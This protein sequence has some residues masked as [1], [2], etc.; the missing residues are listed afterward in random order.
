MNEFGGLPGHPEDMPL[1]ELSTAVQETFSGK[2]GKQ[3]T[4]MVAKMVS[5]KFPGSYTVANSRKY[6]QERW[7]FGPGRQ[8]SVLI[9][10]T[11]QQPASRLGSDVDVKAYLDLVAQQYAKSSGL[12]LNSSESGDAGA[13]NT[14][15]VI[16]QAALDHL[17][18]EQRSL[19]KAVL[20]VYSRSLNTDLR[21]E[22]QLSM[23]L[24]ATSTALLEQLDLWNSEHGDVYASGI[25]PVFNALKAR[26]Y[27]SSWNWALQDLYIMIYD[28]LKGRARAGD[29]AIENQVILLTNR[30]NNKLLNALRY[31]KFKISTQKGDAYRSLDIFL[32]SL[33]KKSE[34]ALESA[35]TAMTVPINIGPLTTVDKLGNIIYTETSRLR[36]RS[37]ILHTKSQS[38][39]D[40]KHRAI[41]E[42]DSPKNIYIDEKKLS[43]GMSDSSSTSSSSPYIS[44]TPDSS[45]NLVPSMNHDSSPPEYESHALSHN[46]D[47]IHIRKKIGV[48]WQF[49]Q[50][51]TNVYLSTLESAASWGMS[52]EDKQVLVTGAGAGSIG[53]EIVQQLLSGGAKV[54]VTTSSYNA[55]T[56]RHFQ[57]LYARYGARTSELVLVP[58]NQGSKRDVE[59]L[60]D[61]IY[62]DKTGLGWDLDHII[63]FAAISENGSEIDNIGSRS[64]L[65]H[66]IMLTNLFRLLG[67]VK[68]QKE[69]FGF[70][71]RPAQVILPLSPNHGI[72]GNDGLYAESKISLETL[73]NKWYSESW[74]EYLSICG[75]IIGWT[76]GTALMKDNDLVSYGIEKRGLRTFSQQEM[77]FNILGLMMPLVLGLTELE[78]I[79]ADLSGGMSSV[80]G[81]KELLGAVRKDINE[82]S[83]IR[84]ALNKEQTLVNAL[85]S[86]VSVAPE[87]AL[88]QRANI[89]FD[90]PRLP[91][92][93]T[94]LE[95]ISTHRK[96]MYD[97]DKVVVIAGFAEVGPLGNARTRWEMEAYGKFSLEGCVELAWIMGLVKY[98]NKAVHG[99][100]YCGLIE[101]SNGEPIADV[102]VK[103]KYEKYILEHSGIRLLEK[104]PLDAAEDHSK[105]FLQEIAIQADLEPFEATRETALDFKREHGD[106]V[107]IIKDSESD[108]YSVQLKKGACLFVPKSSS[109]G[110][111]IGG[112]VPTGWDPKTY[113]ISEDLINQVDH[114]T[115]YTLVCTVEALLSAGITDPYELYKFIHVSE[116]GNMIG[117]GMGGLTSMDKMF[118]QRVLEKPVQKDILQETFINS[119]AAWVNMLLMS[120][121]GTTITPVAACATAIESLHVGYETIISGQAKMCLVGGCDDMSHVSTHEFRNMK[122][123]ID[124]EEDFGRGREAKEMSRPATSTRNGFVEAEGA[125]VQVITTARLALDMG[126]PYV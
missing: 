41:M 25:R 47:Y 42:P 19:N 121:A 99:K 80:F 116:V 117:A 57:D 93:K 36:E 69:K 82:I 114:V 120:S 92:Y 78:P 59:N 112:Q 15:M 122:A 16:D 63:P 102:D 52:F 58:F 124:A 103:A 107:V 95:P 44:P 23:Q 85:T 79:T 43:G 126:L 5:A 62:N 34:R 30:S 88:K 74:G 67:E 70:K 10:A 38:L 56:T 12:N 22:Y 118:R 21:R 84:R 1:E 68:K 33:I 77:A 3:S 8:E 94:D 53:G 90:F 49:D 109:S 60:V 75:A 55:V 66:R 89:K 123:T 39:G 108:T 104:R 7:G 48:D 64:E 31:M 61:Y 29:L 27:D 73:S 9:L 81:L 97:L 65:A 26:R 32:E 50:V 98:Q 96:G 51:Y 113:G 18:A 40:V 110:R 17:Q 6:L 35:P 2:L 20:E 4:G 13:H 45:W 54:I 11:L 71:T 28:I 76:R 91:D 100:P 105:Q 24:Q 83:T 46:N 72:F 106:K 14:N 115:L 37:R 125:G 101:T 87:V 86:G 111:T 119:T